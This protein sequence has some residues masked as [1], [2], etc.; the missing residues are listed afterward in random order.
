[1]R[2]QRHPETGTQS[3]HEI[4]VIRDYLVTHKRNPPAQGR[5]R[6]GHGLRAGSTKGLQEEVEPG[7]S[8]V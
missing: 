7:S 8:N 6:K 1:M 4:R 3:P 5:V 2:Q